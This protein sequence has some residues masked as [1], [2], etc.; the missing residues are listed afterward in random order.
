VV[1]PWRFTVLSKMRQTIRLNGGT[2]NAVVFQSSRTVACARHIGLEST[3]V[4]SHAR[5]RSQLSGA[6]I[7]NLKSSPLLFQY[8][9]TC[10]ASALTGMDVS[11]YSCIHRIREICGDIARD[12][13]LFGSRWT[14]GSCRAICGSPL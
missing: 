3:F 11:S 6:L 10:S 8:S 2:R 7:G 5:S 1:C 12:T 13:S 14:N 4:M 9:S